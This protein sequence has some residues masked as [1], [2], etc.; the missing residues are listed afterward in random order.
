MRLFVGAPQTTHSYCG[1]SI[2]S[3]NKGDLAA[4]AC[5]L[6]LDCPLG[7]A[8]KQT[9]EVCSIVIIIVSAIRTFACWLLSL[10]E[11]RQLSLCD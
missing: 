10:C 9:Q 1:R 2:D 8:V 7:A 6:A 5:E 3:A 4:C 11:L